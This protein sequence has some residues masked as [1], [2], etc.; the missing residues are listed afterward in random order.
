MTTTTLCPKDF[1][2][3]ED[4]RKVIARVRVHIH[5]VPFHSPW[6]NTVIAKGELRR[7]QRLSTKGDKGN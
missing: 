4:K 6:Y 3:V 5:G 1:D 2:L 7:L